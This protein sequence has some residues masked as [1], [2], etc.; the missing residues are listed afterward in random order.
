[1]IERFYVS[2]SLDSERVVVSV[3]GVDLVFG[4][5]TETDLERSDDANAPAVLVEGG[6]YETDD[7]AV[8]DALRESPV[9]T[10][11]VVVEGVEYPYGSSELREALVAAVAKAESNSDAAAER[12]AEVAEARELS[13]A[14][15]GNAAGDTSQDGETAPQEVAN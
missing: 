15:D 8:A 13:E 5:P 11:Q 14:P 6:V 7:G 12:Q 9:L 1:M 4:E 10:S 2:D 3:A